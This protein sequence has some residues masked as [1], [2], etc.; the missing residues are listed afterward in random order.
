MLVG[1]ENERNMSSN[2]MQQCC[3]VSQHFEHDQ[4]VVTRHNIV[5]SCWMT[6]HYRKN[7]MENERNIECNIVAFNVAPNVPFV[8]P[9]LKL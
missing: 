3:I 6:L 4:N 5:A 8:F 2:T 9:G 7:A 1:M